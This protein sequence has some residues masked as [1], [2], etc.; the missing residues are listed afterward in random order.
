MLLP[1]SK[2]TRWPDQF[3]FLLRNVV[4]QVWS[5]QAVPCCW[6]WKLHPFVPGWR[7]SQPAKP[8]QASVQPGM[9]QEQAVFYQ[10]PLQTHLLGWVLEL[11]KKV[12]ENKR[13]RGRQVQRR[14]FKSESVTWTIQSVNDTMPGWLGWGSN[15]ARGEENRQTRSLQAD[16]LHYNTIHGIVA[17]LAEF[18][19]EINLVERFTHW[20]NSPVAVMASSSPL[21]LPCKICSCSLENF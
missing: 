16:R 3:A 10:C 5:L 9:E 17:K 20:H 4:V 7:R 11:E 8:T 6:L 21:I 12:T 2:T 18:S 15:Y 19:L 14:N 13:W 1:I